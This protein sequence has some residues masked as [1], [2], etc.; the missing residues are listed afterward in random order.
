MGAG[1]RA[2][3]IAPIW[4]A[5]LPPCGKTVRCFVFHANSATNGSGL[6]RRCDSTD[7]AGGPTALRQNCLDLPKQRQGNADLYYL[8]RHG[9]GDSNV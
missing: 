4:L 3:A 1:W 2:G 8:F 6:A 7:L 9:T 5:V